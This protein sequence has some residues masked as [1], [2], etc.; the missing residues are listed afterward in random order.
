MG[1]SIGVA[2]T[3]DGLTTCE[4][5]LAA[6]DA[7]VYEAK[8]Q[9]RG[10]VRVFDGAM[11]ARQA[12]R[13]A[14]EE[15][16]AAAIRGGALHVEYQQLV[17]VSSGRALGWEALA[18]WDRPGH[19]LLAAQ[20]FVPVAER[21]ALV[22]E[23]DR[24]VLREGLGR[25]AR[26]TEDGHAADGTLTVNLS[27]RHLRDPSVVRTVRDALDETARAAPPAPDRRP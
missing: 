14:L 26:W 17:D 3:A 23:L 11:R 20:H 12:D 15:E 22:L 4:A 21:S 1:A 5:L 7:A 9:G 13:A 8:A 16:L 19:G 24:W 10:C 18:R 25:L 2:F 27:N 6:A